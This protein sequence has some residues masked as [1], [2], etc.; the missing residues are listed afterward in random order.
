MLGTDISYE[1]RPGP[2]GPGLF[3]FRLAYSIEATSPSGR[4]P[5]PVRPRPYGNWSGRSGGASM[6]VGAGAA[7]TGG[8]S[9]S[10]RSGGASMCVGAGATTG[11]GNW[12][13]RSG[14]A[15]MCVGA[16]AATTG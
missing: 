2:E 7:T 3:H 16:G 12:S 5:G 9:W 15:S 6:C 14:G 8:V 11:G 13:G 1:E 10:G 4:A